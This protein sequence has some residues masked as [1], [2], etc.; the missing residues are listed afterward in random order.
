LVAFVISLF[1]EVFPLQM[2]LYAIPFSF[3]IAS[4][5]LRN[6]NK[7]II[8]DIILIMFIMVVFCNV[9]LV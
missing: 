5:L 8:G 3:F 7:E 4:Y 2:Q 9:Y 6:K 1:V